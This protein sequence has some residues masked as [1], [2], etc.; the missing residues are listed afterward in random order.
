MSLEN[1]EDR[2]VR[3]T[4]FL[5][6]ELLY[7]YNEGLLDE[8]RASEL[9]EFLKGD[10]ET[11]RELE[12]LKKAVQ[13]TTLAASVETS[14]GLHRALVNFEPQW[15]KRLQSWT[16]WSY[17]RGWRYLPYIFVGVTTVLG[18]A[19]IRPWQRPA[20][21]EVTLA[22]QVK[23]EPDLLPHGKAVD[24]SATTVAMTNPVPQIAPVQTDK[25]ETMADAHPS[26]LPPPQ[27][28]VKNPD[29]IRPLAPANPVE[30]QPTAPSSAKKPE[31]AV[32]PSEVSHN[33][34]IAEAEKN[35]EN[36]PA[37]SNMRGSLTRGTMSVTDFHNSWPAIRDK[38][39]AL[40]GSPA[41]SVELGWLRTSKE[42]Y[43]H[44]SLPESNYKELQ[45]FLSTFGPVR[46][47]TERHP[48]VMPKGQI[49][50]ILT[51]KDDASD[52]GSSETP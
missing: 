40:G 27:P 48:R 9:R 23:K 46:F 35:E 7:D 19:V 26:P 33:A 10:R 21:H 45:L 39:E 14:S 6:Q 44:F 5:A 20:Q 8:R 29:V 50:I 25:L 11:Q 49:R 31:A 37:T 3:M 13:Y 47:S 41:G 43:F 24:T 22:E 52:E 42:S 18:I 38:I 4:R 28:V 51:V 1:N 32:T 30:P 12:N 17:Q 34:K 15:Q 2:K 36:E 16:L